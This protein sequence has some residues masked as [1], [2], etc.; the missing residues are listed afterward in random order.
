MILHKHF[1]IQV[2]HGEYWVDIPGKYD[3]ALDARAALA[4]KQTRNANEM[5]VL[6][7]AI[8]TVEEAGDGTNQD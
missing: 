7:M 3:T 6:R 2:L 1:I 4:D 8:E 5:R